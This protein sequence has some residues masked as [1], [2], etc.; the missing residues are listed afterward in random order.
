MARRCTT[1]PGYGLCCRAAGQGLLNAPFRMTD[2]KGHQR[3]AECAQ[4]TKRNGQPGFQFRWHKGTE[5]GIVSG[6]PNLTGG[7]AGAS[8]QQYPIGAGGMINTG[9]V[10]AFR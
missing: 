10:P 3:C 7:T 5:C 4:I 6:C 1:V 9:Q 8:I 2:S